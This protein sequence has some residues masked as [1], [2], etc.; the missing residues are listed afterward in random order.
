MARATIFFVEATNLHGAATATHDQH[1]NEFPGVE[2]F[3]RFDDFFGG[4]FARTRKGID[5]QVHVRETAA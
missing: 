4:A 3:Q 1:V 2:E 5:G